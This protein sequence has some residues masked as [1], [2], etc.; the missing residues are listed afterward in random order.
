MGDAE[1]YRAFAE[2]AGSWW[3]RLKDQTREQLAM[4]MIEAGVNDD[5]RLIH[6]VASPGNAAL[7]KKVEER[8][9]GE[10]QPGYLDVSIN[11]FVKAR[12][13]EAKA[14]VDRLKEEHQTAMES[15]DEREKKRHEE[16]M[17]AQ[18][19]TLDRLLLGEAGGPSLE[20][21]LATLTGDNP[22][23]TNVWEDF[24]KALRKL[25]VEERITRLLEAVPKA[26][27][28]NG[29]ATLVYGMHDFQQQ[30][31]NAKIPT[32]EERQKR[33][34]PAKPGVEKLL[35][36]RPEWMET[37]QEELAFLSALVMTLDGIATGGSEQRHWQAVSHLSA[38]R[39]A[40]FLRDAAET[41]L[42]G[43]DAPHVPSAADITP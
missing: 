12:G 17:K 29:A 30:G 13:P 16:E 6:A 36:M 34:A 31:K 5:G 43:K 11:Q 28:S 18:F 24:Q 20:E 8:L 14:F 40:R 26:R 27:T 32:R 25:S 19:K 10:I 21:C 1:Q 3:A 37:E 4:S 7:V 2:A 9:L 38:E 23:D 42:D 35:S 39:Q 41:L 33:V 15:L 22:K